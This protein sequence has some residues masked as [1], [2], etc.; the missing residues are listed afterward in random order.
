MRILPLIL[1]PCVAAAFLVTMRTLHRPAGILSM[2]ETIDFKKDIQP[3]FVK[4]CTPCHFPGGKMYSSMPFDKDTT[5]LHHADK[6]L[7]RLKNDNEKQLVQRYI[8]E[9]KKGLPVQPQC[10]LKGRPVTSIL[11][12]HP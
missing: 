12:M 3:I 9:N 5:I 4:N 7:K 1:L 10:Y 11:P 8:D 2:Q 6:I